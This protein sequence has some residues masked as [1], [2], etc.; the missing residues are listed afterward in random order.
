M[1]SL[2]ARKADRA[3]R[4]QENGTDPTAN[5]LVYGDGSH[6]DNGGMGNGD[7]NSGLNSNDTNETNPPGGATDN[8]G[9]SLG[10]AG[11]GGG[12]GENGGSNGGKSL[13]EMTVAELDDYIKARNGT[14]VGNKEEKLALAKTLPEAVGGWQA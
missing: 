4:A 1:K 7:D 3:K 13:D 14:P 8:Q 10:G 9:K 12:S 11:A 2:A 5:K 6:L